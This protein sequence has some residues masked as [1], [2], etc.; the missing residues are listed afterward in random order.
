MIHNFIWHAEYP[1][2]AF[3]SNLSR[4]AL[5]SLNFI[6]FHLQS[7]RCRNTVEVRST[8]TA[9]KPIP[10]YSLLSHVLNRNELFADSRLVYSPGIF[11]LHSAS[12]MKWSWS[13]SFAPSLKNIFFLF[14]STIKNLLHNH[15]VV[16]PASRS[17]SHTIRYDSDNIWNFIFFP[18]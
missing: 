16:V 14:H 9:P 18:I 5:S 3:I 4:S 6:L 8:Y 11:I 10:M 15:C 13:W 1:N 17:Y 12:Y 7:H 2:V